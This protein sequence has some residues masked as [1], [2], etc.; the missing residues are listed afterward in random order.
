M[1]NRF[2]GRW[3]AAFTGNQIPLH[4][5]SYFFFQ[6]SLMTNEPEISA[7]I[8]YRNTSYGQIMWPCTN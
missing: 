4:L 7:A 5:G 8:C 1:D 3:Q 6:A 2:R